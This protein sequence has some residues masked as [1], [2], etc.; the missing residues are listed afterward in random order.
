[1]GKTRNQVVQVLERGVH[2]GQLAQV[3]RFIAEGIDE[4]REEKN[5]QK[6]A[7]ESLGDKKAKALM[8]VIEKMIAVVENQQTDIRIFKLFEKAKII[9]RTETEAEF[10][11]TI[12]DL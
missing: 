7:S 8:I 6:P 9:K 1:M 5:L 10:Q 4:L 11:A 2:N 12:A 3:L